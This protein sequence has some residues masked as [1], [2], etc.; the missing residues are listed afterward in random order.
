MEAEGEKNTQTARL[1]KPAKPPDRPGRS[2]THSRAKTSRHVSAGAS[3]VVAAQRKS[4]EHGSDADS[5]RRDA[6]PVARCAALREMPAASAARE[7]VQPAGASEREAARR[8]SGGGRPQQ[9]QK[10]A[11]KQRTAAGRSEREQMA[12]AAKAAHQGESAKSYEMRSACAELCK[13]VK[14]FL[15]PLSR[16]LKG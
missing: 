15:E 14:D 7:T 8:R 10:A 12:R 13:G 3:E 2:P 9:Q 1:A 4:R 11:G 6:T 16:A 5:G